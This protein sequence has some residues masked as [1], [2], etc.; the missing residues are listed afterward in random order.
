MSLECVCL[1]KMTLLWDW[2]IESNIISK[3][4]LTVTNKKCFVQK[5]P[6]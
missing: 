2:V 3:D 4:A 6:I 1:D 5:H